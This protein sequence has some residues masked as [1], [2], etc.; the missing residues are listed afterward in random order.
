MSN[1]KTISRISVEEFIRK[2]F[3]ETLSNEDQFDPDI[4]NL[5]RRH[6][7]QGRIQ[8]KAGNNLADDLVQLAKERSRE[9][10]K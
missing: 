8:S 1:K 3:E 5:V 7:G 6:L 2:L 9:E 4:V 10:E